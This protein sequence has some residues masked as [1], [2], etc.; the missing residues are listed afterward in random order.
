TVDLVLDIVA[1]LGPVG[2]PREH[3]IDPA[4][5]LGMRG[6]RQPPGRERAVGL[7]LGPRGETF[8]SPETVADHPQPPP[9]GDR[10]ILLPQRT[11][12]GVPRI[13]VRRF[14]LRHDRGIERFEILEPEVHLTAHFQQFGYGN[15]RG[16]G[17][18]PGYGLDGARVERDILTG[19]PVPASGAAYQLAVAIHQVQRHPVDLDLA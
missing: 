9:R 16:G 4:D 13:R 18:L 15:L 11:G 3:G 14:A 7:V 5:Q 17:Q 8:G 19:A 1:V 2:D 10:R 12:R 6:H